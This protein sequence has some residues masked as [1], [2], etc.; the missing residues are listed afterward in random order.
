M[1][2]INGKMS[3][4]FPFVCLRALDFCYHEESDSVTLLEAVDMCVTVVAYSADSKRGHQ[5]LVRLEMSCFVPKISSLAES[6]LKYI[7]L[8]VLS[9]SHHN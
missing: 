4:I 6:L 7:V 5:M 9:V 8:G 2:Y 1:A 3:F